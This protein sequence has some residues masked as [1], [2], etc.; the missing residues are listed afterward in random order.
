MKLHRIFR[1][2]VE[3]HGLQYLLSNQSVHFIKDLQP[4]ISSDMTYLWQSMLRD[5]VIRQF[6]NTDGSDGCIHQFSYKY[7]AQTGFD[8]G[9]IYSLLTTLS[10]G[11]KQAYWGIEPS[12]DSSTLLERFQIHES[13][14]EERQSIINNGI[15][16]IQSNGKYGFI[17]SDGSMLIEPQYKSAGLFNEG[18]ACVLDFGNNTYFIN[19]L[20]NK[21]FEFELPPKTSN[22]SGEIGPME[23]GISIYSI[24]N[25]YGLISPDGKITPPIYDYLRMC[26]GVIVALKDHHY[27]LVSSDDFTEITPFD[28]SSINFFTNCF[29]QYTV[30]TLQSGR[31]VLLNRDGR[32]FDIEKE[33]VEKIARY[34]FIDSFILLFTER[35]KLIVADDNLKIHDFYYGCILDDRYGGILHRTTVDI[36]NS[37]ILY[38][39]QRYGLYAGGTGYV[40]IKRDGG[41][42]NDIS[43]T[44]AHQFNNGFAWVKRGNK[45]YRIDLNGNYLC[46][47]KGFEVLTPEYHHTILARN[48]QNGLLALLSHNGNVIFT[49][50]KSQDTEIRMN[51]NYQYII[52]ASE[53]DFVW[54]NGIFTEI[55][56]R[57][58]NNLML[59][60]NYVLLPIDNCEQGIY[61][62]ENGEF[63]V[64]K[65]QNKND[66]IKH[67]PRLKNLARKQIC[68]ETPEKKKYLI[69]LCSNKYSD[70]FDDFKPFCSYLIGIR[71]GLNYLL[72][73]ELN[74]VCSFEQ[75][76]PVIQQNATK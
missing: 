51:R 55:K 34:D 73:N 32:Q 31:N 28:Y 65:L 38:F 50:P 36:P 47:L 13:A 60:S 54:Y 14:W 25:K 63:H 5:V 20:G 1:L 69:N 6:I 57:I 46:S 29:Q 39:R 27:G 26:D 49:F 75:I 15:L 37:P 24:N 74:T 56:G 40:F 21:E 61:D 53:N 43:Y 59:M 67:S 22:Q 19:I 8:Y 2:L 4:S 18:L 12:D 76:T 7:S 23:Y 11:I 42:L 62:L 33:I 41:I 70:L 16:R 71:N 64:V 9:N 45:W 48:L 3:K 30:A 58:S 17:A 66:K 10:V 35:G 44:M 72:D 68:C 52:S